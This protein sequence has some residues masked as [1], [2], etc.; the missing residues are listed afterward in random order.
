M[1]QV[2]ESKKFFEDQQ[3]HYQITMKYQKW[4]EIRNEDHLEVVA[5]NY[6]CRNFA[7][8]QSSYNICHPS[9]FIQ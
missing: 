1:L 5:E 2:W 9:L 6:S 4:Q 7:E 8:A 3:G